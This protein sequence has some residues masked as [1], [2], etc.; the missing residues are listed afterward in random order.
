MRKDHRYGDTADTIA[1]LPQF[2]IAVMAMNDHSQ[3]QVAEMY[4]LHPAAMSRFVNGK[5]QGI[6]ISIKMLDYCEKNDSTGRAYKI[7]QMMNQ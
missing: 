7:V 2:V 4:D 6:D 5:A 1:K 3:R